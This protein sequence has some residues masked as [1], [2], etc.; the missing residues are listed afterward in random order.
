MVDEQQQP[1]P[2]GAGP[3]VTPEGGVAPPAAD[4]ERRSAGR[5]LW[6]EWVKPFLMVAVAVGSIRSAVADWND[7]P[8]GSMRPSILEGDRIVVNK[9]AYDLKIPF[10]RVHL[11]EWGE[12]ARGDIVVFFSPEDGKRL[13]KRVVALPGDSVEVRAN[14]VLISGQ[15]AR[16]AP[17]SLD[18]TALPEYRPAPWDQLAIEDFGLSGHPVLFAE[19][20]G[21]HRWFGPVEVPPE[22]YFVMGDNRD[23]SRDSRAFG[24]VPR[25]RIVGRATAVAASIDPERFFLPRWKRFFRE[26]P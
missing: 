8:T 5:T 15:P 10:T 19:P 16:Y 1:N 7:V 2:Q 21:R 12:P 9:L 18:D 17:L 3:E 25:D 6:R 13:V 20:W 26:L 14:R 23:N 11:L 4:P 24:F 22:H